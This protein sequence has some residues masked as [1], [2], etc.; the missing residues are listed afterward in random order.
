[1]RS[2]KPDVTSPEQVQV[3]GLAIPTS[4]VEQPERV[5]RMWND[6]LERLAAIPGVSAAGLANSLPMD[7]TKNKNPIIAANARSEPGLNP[8]I[9]TFKFGL[10][11][12][13][14]GLIPAQAT[15]QA[16]DE[17][18]VRVPGRCESRRIFSW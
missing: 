17:G 4:Q 6:I 16:S 13:N 9:R 12:R 11:R 2:I 7:D 3:F 8:P 15:C 5:V 1:V 18:P 10:L 14:R